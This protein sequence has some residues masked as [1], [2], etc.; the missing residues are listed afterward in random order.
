MNICVYVFCLVGY[1]N[2]VFF[3]IYIYL[4][5]DLLLQCYYFFLFYV[6]ILKIISMI[7]Y[8][9]LIVQ[10]MLRIMFNKFSFVFILYF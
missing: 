7:Y 4:F 1:E 2:N 6:N 5:N 8:K 3:Y 10:F 9:N